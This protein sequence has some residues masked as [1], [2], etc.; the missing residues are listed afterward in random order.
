[1]RNISQMP[2]QQGE[3]FFDPESIEDQKNDRAHYPISVLGGNQSEED[4]RKLGK[5][6]T[7]QWFSVRTG[8]YPFGTMKGALEG[9]DEALKEMEEEI[10][11]AEKNAV[12]VPRPLGIVAERFNPENSTV[13]KYIETEVA[14]GKYDIYNRLGKL[15]EDS[16]ISVVLPGETGTEVEIM[17]NLHFD[18]K[19]KSKTDLM[20]NPVI[21]VGNTYDNLLKEKFKDLTN[22]SSYI[23]KVN[24]VAEA[25]ILAD[26]LFEESYH[27]KNNQDNKEI[28]E[29]IN[30]FL[31]KIE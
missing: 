25:A 3:L 16:R 28:E 14:E 9:S 5:Q 18:K 30:K 26:N 29:I 10:K 21:F 12:A 11:E 1:M 8:G 15:I 6:L 19:L 4:A 31:Y 20:Q 22:S 27:K 17:S 24:N 23:F 13:G 7:K 2:Q